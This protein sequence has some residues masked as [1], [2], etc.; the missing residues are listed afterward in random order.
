MVLPGQA[1]QVRNDDFSRFD[2][3]ICMDETNRDDLLAMGAPDQKLTLLLD[4]DPEQEL[5]EVPDP[6]YGGP[7][8]F[9]TIYRMIDSA[10]DALLEQL[11]TDG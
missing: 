1:R 2:H 9:E 5:V 8:G 4:H 3:L 6:Y 11:L 7:D 10:C